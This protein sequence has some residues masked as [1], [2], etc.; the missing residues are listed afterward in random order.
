MN[1]LPLEVYPLCT[2]KWISY[3]Q[4]KEE[5]LSGTF[6]QALSLS[7]NFVIDSHDVR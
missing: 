6:S 2:V 5:L 1:F 3:N 4:K 7:V